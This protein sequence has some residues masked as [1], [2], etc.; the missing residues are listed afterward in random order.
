MPRFAL[1]PPRSFSRL[2][3][4]SAARRVGLLCAGVLSFGLGACTTPADPVDAGGTADAG[5]QD[6]GQTQVDAG[7]EVDAGP[8][9]RPDSCPAEAA[10]FERISGE[11]THDGAV[12]DGTLVQMCVHTASGEFLC[13]QP[14]DIDAEGRYAISILPQARCMTQNAARVFHPTADVSALYCEMPVPTDMTRL[15]FDPV[16]P[17]FST[18]RIENAP[19]L[20]DVDA[21]VTVATPSGIELTFKPS[22][23]FFGD[24]DRATTK[25]AA[26][27]AARVAP[28]A[29]PDCAKHGTANLTDVF[30][31]SPETNLRGDTPVSARLP[32]TTGIA[33]GGAVAVWM[34]GGLGCKMLD[35]TPVAEAAWVRLPDAVVSADGTMVELDADV[36][37]SCLNTIA[38]GTP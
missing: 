22:T 16:M 2:V 11:T 34:Q 21:D 8:A 28:S 24:A 17:L 9:M 35:D 32:N 37:L 33:A 23:L 13:L 25:L 7:P 31:F 6:A 12:L 30:V 10:W 26:L 18:E 19:T 29:L 38:L 20:T 27:A 5:A 14:E 36:G 1:L 4:V 15:E 3:P